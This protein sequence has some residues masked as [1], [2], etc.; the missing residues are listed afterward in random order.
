MGTL[1]Y[2]FRRKMFGISVKNSK[3]CIGMLMDIWESINEPT[4]C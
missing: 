1:F 2:N 3:F 4:R